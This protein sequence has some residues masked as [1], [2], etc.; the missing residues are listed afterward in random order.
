M[1]KYLLILFVFAS[2]L[3]SVSAQTDYY[4]KLSDSAFELTK[5]KVTYDSQ[6]RK[7]DYP[8]GVVPGDKVVCTDVIIRAYRKLE[9]VKNNI[10]TNND[11]VSKLPVITGTTV[12]PNPSN[13]HFNI[14]LPPQTKEILIYNS[15]GR[16]INKTKME[17][18]TGMD[19]YVTCKGIY[20]IQ[21]VTENQIINK[22]LIV[23]E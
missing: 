21:I 17:G 14:T 1:K 13:G 2:S 4:R 9:N 11:S 16:L 8:N 23:S 12:Y 15:H 3:I 22:K 7:L 6:Y 5:Q 10:E 18:Q 19:Y 20:L